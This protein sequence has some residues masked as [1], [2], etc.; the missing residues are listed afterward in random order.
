[1]SDPS[2]TPPVIQLI[3]DGDRFV[4]GT[5][6]LTDRGFRY[7]MSYFETFALHRGHTLFLTEHLSRIEHASASFEPPE[8]WRAASAA[9]LREPA[10]PDG[11]ARIYITAG[12]GSPTDP[13]FHPR[14]AAILE[15]SPEL[16][17]HDL[18]RTITTTTIE[19]PHTP[20]T[21]LKT[22]NYWS[23]ILARQAADAA[24]KD[25]AILTTAHGRMFSGSMSNVFFLRGNQLLTP[26]LDDGARDGVVRGWVRRNFEATEESVTLDDLPTLSAAFLTNSRIGIQGI[27]R[28][29]EHDL[30]PSDRVTEIRETYRREV[31]DA[32]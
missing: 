22:G 4:P 3:L 14:V 13:P 7:G 16:T 8:E 11:V 25:D 23:H 28:I 30:A 1:M 21:G 24:G 18:T 19:F 10:I 9:L 12:D 15:A 27:S 29:N 31:L 6:P 20:T 32:H 5:L 26:P 17:G 2:P